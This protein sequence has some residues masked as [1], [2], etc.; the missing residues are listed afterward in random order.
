MRDEKFC[1]FIAYLDLDQVYNLQMDAMARS[2]FEG[3]DSCDDVLS[4]HFGSCPQC[5]A[6]LMEAEESHYNSLPEWEKERIDTE[7]ERMR[8]CIQKTLDGFK[9]KEDC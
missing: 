7:V 9:E 6:R 2:V 8:K 1:D 4:E 5:Y 3:E